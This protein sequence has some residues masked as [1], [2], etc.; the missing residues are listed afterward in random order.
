M[1]R[2]WFLFSSVAAAIAPALPLPTL[3][4]IKPWYTPAGVLPPNYYRDLFYPH[5][6]NWNDLVAK[7]MAEEMRREIDAEIIRKLTHI[8]EEIVT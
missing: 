6:E 8:G 4:T 5:I 1:N 2:R 3:P 7:K